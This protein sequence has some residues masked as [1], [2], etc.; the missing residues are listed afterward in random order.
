[1]KPEKDLLELSRKVIQCYFKNKEVEVSDKIKNKYSEKQACFV[2]LTKNGILRGCVGSLY[3]HQPLYKD[4]IDNS[5]NAAFRDYRFTPLNE[6]ELSSIKIEIS[7]LSVAKKL[8][9]SSSNE[10]LKKLNYSM[11]VILKKDSRQATYL[12]QVWEQLP[13]KIE[14]LSSLCL[15]AGLAPDSWKN[16]IEVYTYSVEKVKE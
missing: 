3:A 2:T 11:G 9:F 4:V 14:F 16:E 12:P 15:K 1:M 5:I 6:S 8:S 7:V 10:L 13:D